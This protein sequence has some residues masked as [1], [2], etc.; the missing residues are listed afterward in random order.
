MF[1]ALESSIFGDCEPKKFPISH[2]ENSALRQK[3]FEE[4]KQ[5]RAQKKKGAR[6]S[7]EEK[8]VGPFCISFVFHSVGLNYSALV[9][10]YVLIHFCLYDKT[11]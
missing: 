8:K 9:I 6:Q 5:G 4:L 1:V 3:Q 10:E 2:V 11:F 7:S